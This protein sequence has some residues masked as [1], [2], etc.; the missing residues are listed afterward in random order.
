MEKPT[1]K[2][3]K[4]A[5]DV[6]GPLSRDRLNAAIG[7]KNEIARLE[8][9]RDALAIAVRL[10]DETSTSKEKAVSEY[11]R[12][13]KEI[14]DLEKTAYTLCADTANAKAL[15]KTAQEDLATA[16]QELAQLQ[17]QAEA[18]RAIIQRGEETQRILAS[19]ATH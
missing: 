10:A 18:A 5:L 15:W 8:R 13:T 12:L 6:V 14:A 2:E 4:E 16:R 3:L 7:L 1:A 9:V 11:E 19:L 17:E